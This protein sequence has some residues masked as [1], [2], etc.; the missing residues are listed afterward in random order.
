MTDFDSKVM[1]CEKVHKERMRQCVAKH[2]KMD[3]VQVSRI[4]R[5]KSK[6]EKLDTSKREVTAALTKSLEQQQSDMDSLQKA[7]AAATVTI[8]TLRT[9]MVD[10]E[11]R[12]IEDT[13]MI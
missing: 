8:A 4:Q 9:S 12:Y 5:L 7:H 2:E 13:R 6:I 10:M 3:A 11:R 1:A